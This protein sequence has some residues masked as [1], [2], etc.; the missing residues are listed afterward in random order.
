MIKYFVNDSPRVL[1]VVL[2][3]ISWFARAVQSL[4]HLIPFYH[5]VHYLYISAWANVFYCKTC[6]EHVIAVI[7]SKYLKAAVMVRCLHGTHEPL[8]SEKPR[9]KKRGRGQTPIRTAHSSISG[10]DEKGKAL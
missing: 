10:K 7:N 4:T 5:L 8:R 9:S 2:F 3:F 6:G 1:F